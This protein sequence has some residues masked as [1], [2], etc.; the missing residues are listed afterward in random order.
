MLKIT[1]FL[2]VYYE[3]HIAVYTVC[4]IILEKWVIT[5]L[6]VAVMNGQL[7]RIADVFHFDRFII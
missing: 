7:H 6:S 3:N 5:T 1:I 4:V 2:N